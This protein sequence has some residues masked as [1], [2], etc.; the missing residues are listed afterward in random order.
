MFPH[1]VVFCAIQVTAVVEWSRYRIVAGLVT[2]SSPVPLK[3]RRVE[4]RYTLNLSRAQTLS[5]WCGVVAR[6]RGAS[7]G[8]V[9]VTSSWFKIT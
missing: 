5:R 3:T 2:S 4:R 1:G 6:R 9:H 7:S 8:V